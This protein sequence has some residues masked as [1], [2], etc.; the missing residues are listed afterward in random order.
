MKYISLKDTNFE[1]I[2]RFLDRV[3]EHLPLKSSEQII[4]IIKEINDAKIKTKPPKK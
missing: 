1:F 2:K 4:K 3:G